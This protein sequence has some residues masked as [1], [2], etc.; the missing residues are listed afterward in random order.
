MVVYRQHTRRIRRFLS[1]FK[2]RFPIKE[3]KSFFFFKEL[4]ENNFS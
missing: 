3:T 2:K 1:G 4:Q